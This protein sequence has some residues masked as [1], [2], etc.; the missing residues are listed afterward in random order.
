MAVDTI[1]K[2]IYSILANDPDV[3]GLVSTRVYPL[4]VPQGAS[5]PAITYEQ[6]SGPREHTMT[7]PI[8]MVPA[9]FVINCWSSTY[10]QSRTLADYVRIALDGYAGTVGSQKI[11]VAM[12]YNE[13]D[14]IEQSPDIKGTRRYAKQLT[15]EMWFKEATS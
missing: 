15:F 1:E 6:N 4:I 3:E 10:A 13:N 2:A 12:L 8:G 14:I 11:Y 9:M 7:G 5:M